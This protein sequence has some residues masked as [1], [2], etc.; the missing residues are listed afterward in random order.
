[1]SFFHFIKS[2]ICA[3][4]SEITILSLAKSFLNPSIHACFLIRLSI[5][6]KSRLLHVLVRN[7]LITKHSI[8]IGF[9]AVIGRA[10]LLPHPMGIVIGEGVVI[11]DGVRI[12]QNCTMGNKGGYPT[13][14]SCCVIYPG[15]VIVGEVII[16]NSCVIGA[17]TFLDK[18]LLENSS[19]YG[20]CL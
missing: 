15:S 11:G 2:D 13:I 8:D 5:A 16:G 6:C 12:Y 3:I 19:F 20:Q 18:N 7:V 14:G 10:L 4:Y 1:M 17:N 9:G